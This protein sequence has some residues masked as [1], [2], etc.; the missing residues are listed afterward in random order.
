VVALACDKKVLRKSGKALDS[1]SLAHEYGF[2]DIDGSQPVWCFW[3][4]P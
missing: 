3:T 4:D 1:G 2:T